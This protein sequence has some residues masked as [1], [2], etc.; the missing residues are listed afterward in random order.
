MD[1]AINKISSAE[2]N[3]TT[4]CGY[5]A[6]DIGAFDFIHDTINENSK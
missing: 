1:G 4:H 5:I 6:T 3:A 2:K